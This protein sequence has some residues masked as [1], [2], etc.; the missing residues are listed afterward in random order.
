MSNPKPTTTVQFVNMFTAFGMPDK[1]KATML[2]AECPETELKDLLAA[3]YICERDIPNKTEVEA[4]KEQ[5]V[6]NV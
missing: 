2:L 4:Y 5:H 6:R 3:L 1:S